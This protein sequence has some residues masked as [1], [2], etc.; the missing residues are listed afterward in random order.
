MA[1]PNRAMCTVRRIDRIDP[2]DGADR[3]E[4]AHV[5]GWGVVVGKSEFA[6]GE[7]ALYFEIDTFM[8]VSDERFAFLA[9]RGT[10]KMVWNGKEYEGHVLR[11][12]K[13]RGVYSQGLLMKPDLWGINPDVLQK[14]CDEHIDMSKQVGVW[15]WYKPVPSADFIGK[16]DPYVAPRTNA[17]RIQNIDQETFD[18][19][20]RTYYEVSVKVDGTSVTMLYDDRKDT[21]RIFSHNNEFDLTTGMGKLVYDT[22]KAQGL[23]D[24]CEVNHMI[25]LQAEM[26]GPKIQGDRLGLGKHRLFVFSIWDVEERRYVPCGEI[27]WRDNSR[28]VIDSHVPYFAPM[29][30]DGFLDLFDTPNDLLEGI[31]GKRGGIT[32]DRLDEGVVVHIYD[33]GDLTD[34]EWA[35]LVSTLGTTL[36]V[37]AVSNRYLLKSKE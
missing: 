17:E 5:G 24:F 34:V 23:V 18:L 33:R 9:P 4:L 6:P 27:C 26:C 29:S 2:I 20:K 7:Y 12:A 10:R 8:P 1:N 16:Y 22:A 25:T 11:T 36:Q 21:L 3:I 32:K 28:S 14:L 13:L 19:I 31:D 37:K 15:E 35:W 30:S